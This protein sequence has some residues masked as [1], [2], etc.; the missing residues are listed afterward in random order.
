[1]KPHPVN[2][3]HHVKTPWPKVRLGEVLMHFQ[4]NIEAPEPRMYPKLSVK[5][6]EPVL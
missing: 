5:I 1:M 2:P 3:V 4:K 6:Y